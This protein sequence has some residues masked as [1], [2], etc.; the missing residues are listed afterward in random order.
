MSEFNYCPG[1]GTRLR[2]ELAEHGESADQTEE[3]TSA[4]VEIARIQAE[5]D[6]AVAKIEKGIVEHT[7]DVEQAAELAHA[8][9]QAEGMAAAMAPPAE[10]PPAEPV[11]V[12]DTD[13][14]PETIPPA[15]PGHHEPEEKREPAKR[16]FF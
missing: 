16:G 5:R 10:Q 14:E 9:G 7:A 3:I 15:D 2:E 4:E 1:C 11:V 13:V 12:V 6:V 8:E